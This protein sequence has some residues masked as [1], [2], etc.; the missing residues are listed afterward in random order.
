MPHDTTVGQR[1]H[2][3]RPEGLPVLHTIP[4]SHMPSPLPRRN[5]LGARVALLPQRRR[6]SPK[7]RRV[8]FRIALF[9]ACSAF[10]ARYGLRAR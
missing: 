8:G 2:A 4:L 9:E 1:R 7:L 10:T 6:P 3:S 5:R